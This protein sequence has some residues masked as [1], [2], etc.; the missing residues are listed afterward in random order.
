MYVVRFH[1]CGDSN[2]DKNGSFFTLL[3]QNAHV[4]K[5]AQRRA[6]K[7]SLFRIPFWK[8]F[9]GFPYRSPKKRKLPYIF[10]SSSLYKGL[11]KGLTPKKEK[12]FKRENFSEPT[13]A[14]MDRDG[15]GGNPI[16]RSLQQSFLAVCQTRRSG[17]N[18]NTPQ[19]S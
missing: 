11:K 1:Q 3:V 4:P 2:R 12:P 9:E 17:N 18:P 6:Q 14:R 19:C 5:L 16:L 7:C 8:P 15:F 10:L 13:V